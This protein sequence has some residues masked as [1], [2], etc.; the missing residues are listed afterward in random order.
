MSARKTGYLGPHPQE[1]GTNSPSWGGS[2]S[3]LRPLE[4]GTLELTLL[5]KIG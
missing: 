5:W 4:E 2:A 1:G 3:Q